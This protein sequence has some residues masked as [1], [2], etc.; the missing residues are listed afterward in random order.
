MTSNSDEPPTNG[1]PNPPSIDTVTGS[2]RGRLNFPS[3]AL[4]KSLSRA[5]ARMHTV[6]GDHGYHVAIAELR[7]SPDAAVRSVSGMLRELA[8]DEYLHRWTLTKVL[9]DLAHPA[10]LPA[11]MSI[12]TA[13][14]PDPHRLQIAT[15]AQDGI[16]RMTA[17]EG[18]AAQAQAGDAQ[19]NELLLSAVRSPVFSVR[20]AAAAA[21]LHTGGENARSDLEAALAEAERWVLDLRAVSAADIAVAAP[22]TTAGKD[23]TRETPAPPSSAGTRAS[24]EPTDDA[25]GH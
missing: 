22:P 23:S 9:A 2:A 21:Y 11:L 14:P 15:A 19:A 25:P 7:Q 6:Q 4:G 5:V 20:R 13:P 12:A 8:D 3:G 16:I 10:A 17:V 1:P 24:V 18:I